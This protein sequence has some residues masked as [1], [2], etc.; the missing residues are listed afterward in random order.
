MKL[1]ICS[2]F[3]AALLVGT[4]GV[5]SSSKASEDQAVGPSAQ[6]NTNPHLTSTVPLGNVVKVGVPQSQTL[7][8]ADSSVVTQVRPHQ[9]A[10]RAAATLYVR[11]VP[12]VTFL[13]PQQLTSKGV[14]VASSANKASSP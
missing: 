12:I 6:S 14:K 11:N 13:S 1:K 5:A 8:N 3:A 10:D 7:N 9:L 4:I 2:G